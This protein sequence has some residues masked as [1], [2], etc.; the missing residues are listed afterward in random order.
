MIPA[1]HR[2]FILI[3]GVFDFLTWDI[4]IL[5]TYDLE[6]FYQADCT[7]RWLRDSF[8]K[9]T[10]SAHR[11]FNISGFLNSHAISEEGSFA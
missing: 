1:L 8:L 10:F 4:V 9:T 11:K 6:I 2:V 3:N 7:Y 5:Q